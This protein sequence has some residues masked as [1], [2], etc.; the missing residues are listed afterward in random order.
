MLAYLFIAV[1]L[2]IRFV[3]IFMG[4][5][6]LGFAPVGA[7]L[8]YFGAN[9]SRK[10]MA[11][12]LAL[13]CASDICLNLFAYHLP[14]T[15]DTFISTG[16]YALAF[17]LGTLLRENVDVLKVVGAS[18]AGSASFFLVSNFGVWVAFNMYPHTLSGLG[19]C[20]LAA[21]P[22]FRNGVA[23]E[24]VYAIGFFYLPVALSAAQRMFLHS[25]NEAAA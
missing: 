11:I 7:S 2:I 16:W 24:L 12:P 20:Y 4:V 13:F 3:P 9:R 17:L 10:E 14:V 15:W 6:A 5:P 23:T 19:A 1:A 22:F 25:S 18:A 21:I 8:L